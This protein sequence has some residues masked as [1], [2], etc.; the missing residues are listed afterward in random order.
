[1]LTE[2][3]TT[4]TTA[5]RRSSGHSTTSCAS[6]LQVGIGEIYSDGEESKLERGVAGMGATRDSRPHHPAAASTRCSSSAHSGFKITCPSGPR[7][8]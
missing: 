1:M 4:T 2:V 8:P 7:K 3:S 6:T 5:L